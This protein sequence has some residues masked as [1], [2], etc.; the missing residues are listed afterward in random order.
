MIIGTAGHI[1]HGKSALV[2]ALTGTDPDRLIEEKERGMTIDLGFAFLNDEIAFIDVPGHERFI[3]NMVAGVSTINMAL[4]VIAADD[5]VMPQTRE[6]LDILS[7]LGLQEGLVAITKIDLVDADLLQL[8]QQELKEFLKGSFLENAP[9]YKVSSLTG[10][11]IDELRRGI[12]E[13]T[14]RVK[15]RPDR[16]VFWLPVDR[17][18]IM[19]GFG[20]VVTG[21][22]L[23]GEVRVGDIVEILPAGLTAKVRGLQSHGKEAQKLGTGQ[24]AAINLQNIKRE[25]V[26]RGD[27]ITVPNRF[28]ASKLFDVKLSLLPHVKKDLTNRTRVRL[29][30]G[31]GELMARVKLLDV[32]KLPGGYSAL[33]QLQLEA[34]A[35]AMRR[36]PFI[37]RQYSPPLTIG[38]GIILD[39]EAEPHRR[40]DPTIIARLQALQVPD[41]NESVA[42]ALTTKKEDWLSIEELQQITSLP[43]ASIRPVLEQRLKENSLRQFMGGGKAMYIHSQQFNSIKDRIL[44]QIEAFHRRE[45]LKPAMSKAELR[46]QCGHHIPP[47]LFDAALE[48]LIMEQQI[49]PTPQGV[50]RSGYTIKLSAEEENRARMVLQALDE[51]G[52]TPPDEATLAAYVRLPKQEIRKILSALIGRGEVIRLEGEI[53]FTQKTIARA[54]EILRELAKQQPEFSVSE[55]RERLNTSRKFAVPLLTYF[56]EKG[57]TE[58]VGDVR[59]IILA[60]ES[61]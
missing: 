10:E 30:V 33:A 54:E 5:G 48:E 37:I 8:L 17:S 26:R 15:P 2:K 3:K 20:T 51:K 34:P 42:A 4:L 11:G 6:H 23:S 41:V 36:D 44:E 39:A 55:F 59:R 57:I 31:T 29:H 22:V 28:K 18:F 52:F 50:K 61:L 1:D 56:D 9:V 45:P 43:E 19:R 12:I 7:L 46:T 47:K 32:E 35:V 53:Y 40:F 60:N 27:V 38:G 24:R 13:M 16:G 58:R 14:R 21:S 25:Q 49:E